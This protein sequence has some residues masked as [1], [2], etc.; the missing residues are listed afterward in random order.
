MSYYQKPNVRTFQRPKPERVRPCNPETWSLPD[1]PKQIN[2]IHCRSS[3]D[4]IQYQ[5]ARKVASVHNTEAYLV[6]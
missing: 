1:L 4:N 3:S 6:K 5:T 2:Y